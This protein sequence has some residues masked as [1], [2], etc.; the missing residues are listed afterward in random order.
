[1]VAVKPSLFCVKNLKEPIQKQNK[2][3]MK[4]YLLPLLM[5]YYFDWVFKISNDI[6]RIEN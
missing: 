5:I 1:M 4:D 3:S 2:K 6:Q